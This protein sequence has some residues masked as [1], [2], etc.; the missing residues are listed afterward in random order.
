MFGSVARG[1]ADEQSDIDFF[2]KAGPNRSPVFPGEVI[3]ELEEYLGLKV[4]VFT[5]NG[6]QESIR[7]R[8]NHILETIEKYAQSGI[9]VE[10]GQGWFKGGFACRLVP[11]VSLLLN[12]R[13]E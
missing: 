2:V 11:S 12:Y 8:L 9:C 6:L 5:E 13:I 4:D 3:A 1:E 7:E 10:M